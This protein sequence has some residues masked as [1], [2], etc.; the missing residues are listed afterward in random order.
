LFVVQSRGWYGIHSNFTNNCTYLT[1]YMK[2][3]T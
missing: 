3:K 2:L 1:G